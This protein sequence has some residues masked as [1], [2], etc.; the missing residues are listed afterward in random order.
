MEKDSF[1]EYTAGDE[2]GEA[3][4]VSM[5]MVDSVCVWGLGVLMCECVCMCT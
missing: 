4:E 3:K 2:V 5:T 1:V